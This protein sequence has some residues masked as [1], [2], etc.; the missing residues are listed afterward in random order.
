TYFNVPYVKNIS[1]RFRYCVRDLDVRLSYTGINTLRK[2]IK[3]GKDCLL[4]DSRSNIVYKI[5]C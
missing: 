5:N 3:V 1:E 2:F 4:N